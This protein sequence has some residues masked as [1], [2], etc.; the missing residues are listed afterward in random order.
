MAT[1]GSEITRTLTEHIQKYLPE[2]SS[3]SLAAGIESWT[4]EHVKA[5]SH[6][7]KV[8]LRM[9]PSDPHRR[10]NTFN[11]MQMRGAAGVASKMVEQKAL[12]VTEEPDPQGLITHKMLRLTAVVIV[13]KPQL[14]EEKKS[15]IL[16][17]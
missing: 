15:P 12:F 17:T 11:D 1:I 5:C 2:V 16:A 8:D 3:S 9:M 13:L 10:E 7:Q 6:I 4:N 14:P